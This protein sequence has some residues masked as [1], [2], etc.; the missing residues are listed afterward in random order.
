MLKNEVQKIAVS[1]DT[2][3]ETLVDTADNQAVGIIHIFH[4]MS[5]H[6]ER[7]DALVQVLNQN[8]YHVIRHN[9]RGHGKEID[10]K[11]GHFDSIAQVVQDAYEI[12]TTYRSQ[13]EDHLPYIVLGHSMGSIIARQ[14]LQQH[15]NE[16]DGMILS[17][18]G[19]FPMWQ[20]VFVIPLLKLITLI[21]SKKRITKWLNYIMVQQFNKPFKP[22]RT[23]SDWLSSDES[24]VDAYVND[25]YSGFLVSNQLIYSVVKSMI[26]TGRHRNIK[27]IKS[28]VP[29]LMISGKEDSFGEQ[30]KGVRRLG[31]KLK[32][33][34][35]EHITIQL[36]TNK[37]HEILFEKDHENVWKHML[38]W[39]SRQIIRKK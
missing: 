34:G 38:D 15:S 7:Y 4:G 11:R 23:P 28:D 5:E 8:G 30:G 24:Q 18:T 27:K 9:H 31:Q 1:D 17:G 22:L 35:I 2:M 26:Q 14:Y 37:R 6:M 16:V 19:L 25:P 32:K 29:I 13:F 12:Q 21:G 39:I 3:I 10:S 20:G 33:G 36:Y